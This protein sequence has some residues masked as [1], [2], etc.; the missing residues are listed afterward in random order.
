LGPTGLVITDASTNSISLQWQDRASNE[1]AYEIWRAQPGGSYSLVTTIAANSTSYTDNNLSINKPY[2]YMVRAKRNTTNSGYSNVAQGYTY[3]T[4]V[5]V[6]ITSGVQAPAP[7]YNLNSLPE[8]DNV[9]NNLNDHNNVPSSMSMI[10]YGT[11]AGHFTHGRSTNNN[12]GV[13]PDNVM[14]EGYILF[15]GQN[16][17]MRLKGL[18]VAMKY[19]ITLFGST[20][21]WG[22]YNAVYTIG[23]RTVMLNAS[24][25][26]K[27]TVT[28]YDVVP[29][30]NGEILITIGPGT[31]YTSYAVLNALIIKG[32]IPSAAAPPATPAS[33]NLQQEFVV[34]AAQVTKE[35]ET[36]TAYPNPFN[37]Q[38]RLNLQAKQ[39]DAVYVDLFDMT[40]KVLYRQIFRNMSPGI[41]NINLQFNNKLAAGTYILQV[42]IGEGVKSNVIKLVKR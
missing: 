19:D 32:Y 33:A 28:I 8:I 31:P 34:E 2:Y 1:T 18:N 13:F 5:Q 4:I 36:V 12:S 29:D 30:E 15:Q 16:P 21:D 9:W 26:T 20:N 25:N 7:W 35:V 40:G 24:V 39:G 41:N 10:D 22:D 27:G 38:V 17:K 42:R 23:N 3:G 37:D 14:K 6:N 11:W